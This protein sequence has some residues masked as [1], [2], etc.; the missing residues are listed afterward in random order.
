MAVDLQKA[1]ICPRKAFLSEYV[2]TSMIKASVLR[3]IMKEV[4]GKVRFGVT[5]PKTVTALIKKGFADHQTGMFGFEAEG[6]FER[7]DFLIQRY[8]NFER[9]TMHHEVLA[10]DLTVEVTFCGAKRSVS[11]HKLVD[12]GNGLEAIR[13]KYKTPEYSYQTKNPGTRADRC[14]ELLLL[15]LAGEA[16]AKKLGIIKPVFGAI[17]YMKSRTE[18][19]LEM[20]ASFESEAGENIVNHHFSP[21]EAA[22]IEAEYASVSADPKTT[23]CDAK[24]CRN[25]YFDELCHMEFSQR[26]KIELPE[27]P[28]CPIDEIHM[29][30]AQSDFVDFNEGVCRV[31]AVA[32]SGKTTIVTLR[33]LRLIEDGTDPDKILMITFTDKAAM[34]MKRRLQEYASGSILAGEALPVDKVV[35]GTFNSWGQMLLDQHYKVLGFTSRPE[36][37]DDIAKKDIVVD[38]LEKHRSLPLDYKN[39]FMVSRS[40]K[41]AVLK[42]VELIDTM[43]SSHVTTPTDVEAA[44]NDVLFTP[45]SA[46]L[47]AMYEEYNERLVAENKIDYEDQ[48]RLIL[49]LKSTGVFEALPYEHIVIDEFQDS[50]PNQ[51]DLIVQIMTLNNNVK[52]LVVVGDEMQSIYGFRNATPENLVELSKYFPNIIDINLEDNF[53]SETPIIRTANHIIERESKLKKT[54]KAHKTGC[55]FEPAIRNIEKQEDEISL[56]VRQTQKL[57]ADGESPRNIAVLCRTKGELIKIQMAM[58]AAGVPTMLKVPEVV[59][60]SPYVKAIISLASYI[61]DNNNLADLALYAKSMGQDPFDA[62]ALKKSGEAIMAGLESYTTEAGKIQ[63][64]CDMVADARNDY[65]AAEFMEQ[66]KKKNFNSLRSVLQHCLKYRNYKTKETFSTAHEDTNCVT[67]I[68]IH[69]AKGLEWKVVLLSLRKFRTDEEERRL[70]YVAV[71]RAKEKLVITH[72][73]KQAALTEL[74][75]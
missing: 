62:D 18:K 46:E 75:Y 31:N 29:T 52:S 37:V 36:L 33:T 64:F 32:G 60:D 68:T 48:L 19:S 23:S 4:L 49:N 3:S 38:L 63:F 50:N 14:P 58:D 30:P 51:I 21:T 25:C 15:Q 47:L 24:D 17:Y 26:K 22:D 39:P 71:T 10:Q 54:I 35:I 27:L 55:G 6:E 16:T 12:R 57:I 9:D 66:L 5:R 69:S 72:T 70:L 7:M 8:M 59:G 1:K 61:L 74:L 73:K 44:V 42:V 11:I 13:Y 40:Y 20:A 45:H 67:L 2:P 56:F 41:G 53:R 43:K 28:I 34:E 65:I